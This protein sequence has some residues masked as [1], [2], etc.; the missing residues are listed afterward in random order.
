METAALATESDEP[1]YL[2]DILN[3]LD[4]ALESVN[5]LAAKTNNV[6]KSIDKANNEDGANELSEDNLRTAVLNRTV[7][8]GI[9]NDGASVSCGKPSV[10]DCGRFTMVKDPF[11]ATG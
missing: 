7:P 3:D 9:A 5:S 11:I 10:S 4:S 2:S 8:T 6:I 1:D